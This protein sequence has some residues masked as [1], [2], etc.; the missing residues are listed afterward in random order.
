MAAINKLCGYDKPSRPTYERAINILFYS[1]E[2]V[3]SIMVFYVT[4]VLFR[5]FV[6]VFLIMVILGV[7]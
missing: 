4:L 3:L 5:L 6:F 1:D 2:I 7:R